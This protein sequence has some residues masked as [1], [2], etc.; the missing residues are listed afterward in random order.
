MHVNNL[1]EIFVDDDRDLIRR[2]TIQSGRV[3]VCWYPSAGLDFRHIRLLEEESIRDPAS[4]PPLIFVHTDVSLPRKWNGADSRLLARGDEIDHGMRV[5]DVREIRTKEVIR[6]ISREVCDFGFVENIG[7]VFLFSV[8]IRPLF[9][10]SAD[11]V[12]VPIIYF[13]AENL[14]FLVRV[15]LAN[16][17]PVNT[18]VH[19]CDGGATLGGSRIPM[20]FIY[21]VADVLGIEH[22]ISDSSL[23]RKHFNT[24]EDFRVLMSEPLSRRILGK[25]FSE[26]S[27]E[28]IRSHWTDKMV[29]PTLMSRRT[30]WEVD[31][32]NYFDWRKRKKVSSPGLLAVILD[33]AVDN[34]LGKT[35]NPSVC[36][37]LFEVGAD[38]VTN[39]LEILQRQGVVEELTPVFDDRLE[40]WLGYRL[41]RL[42]CELATAAIG[43]P[44]ARLREEREK[45]RI[46]REIDFQADLR[47]REEARKARLELERRT[48]EKLKRAKLRKKAKALEL[49]SSRSQMRRISR[50]ELLNEIRTLSPCDRATRFATD[51]LFNARN[52]ELIPDELIPTKAKDL[53]RLEVGLAKELL[54]KIDRRRH[55]TWG[56]LRLILETNLKEGPDDMT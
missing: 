4:N 40:L 26:I 9:N 49:R 16:Q 13:T 27:E 50:S 7:R 1:L 22:V 23:G 33:F 34:G 45:Y 14:T 12:H 35:A 44:N 5:A 46:Q 18:L 31:Y 24:R 19:I 28:E 30:P 32:V 6:E 21:Q 2:S 55:G 38:V 10:R 52:L 56:R 54:K 48:S 25:S 42:G 51:A 39:Y 20:N 29:E 47:S 11:S 17:I 8:E 41:S 3:N 43:H 37:D 53:K 36:R 15:L